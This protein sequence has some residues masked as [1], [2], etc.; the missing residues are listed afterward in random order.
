MDLVAAIC[1]RLEQECCEVDCRCQECDERA[2]ALLLVLNVHQRVESGQ[3]FV[4][5]P[6][7]YGRV[8]GVCSACGVPD[9]Y[10]V[11]WPC[12]TIEVIARALGLIE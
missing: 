4:D 11:V 7:R 9:E 1:A 10:A 2:Q 3:G 5:G 12:S 8:E 6:E